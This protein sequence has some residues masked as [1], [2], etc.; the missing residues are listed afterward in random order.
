MIRSLTFLFFFFHVSILMATPED[1]VADRVLGQPNFTAGEQGLIATPTILPAPVDV[2]VA[3][4]GRLYV[5][6]QFNSRILSWP[7]AAGFTN[8]QAADLVIG[9]PDLNSGVSNNGGVSAT[10]LYQQQGIAVD[11]AGNLYVADLFNNRVLEYD[12]PASNDAA[13]DRVFGQPNFTSDTENNGGISA[14]SLRQPFDMDLDAAGNLYIGD[15]GNSRIL[16]YDNPLAS[17]RVADAVIGQGNNFTTGDLNKGGVSA[18]SLAG[19]ASLSID[20]AGQVYVADYLNNRVL[21]YDNPRMGSKAAVQVFGQPNFTSAAANNGGISPTSLQIPR[22]VLIDGSG[23]LYV[24][25]SN[26]SRVLRYD[27]AAV[28]DAVAD[29]QIGQVDFFSGGANGNGIVKASSLRSPAGL[30][31]DAAGDLIVA[32]QVNGRVLSF[33]AADPGSLNFSSDLYNANEA[34]GTATIIVLRA[35]DGDGAVSVDYAAA[36]GTA[37]DADFTPATGTL[38]FANGETSKTFTV[39]IASDTV[40]DDGETVLLTLSNPTGGATLGAVTAATL[41]IADGSGTTGGGAGGD[42]GGGCSLI[43]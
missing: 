24:S 6:D 34:D 8:Q 18:S 9:Q 15:W 33:D 14:S 42:S 36:S 39:I 16:I 13:A 28:T 4:S 21:R 29:F 19:P 2:A 10:S 7:S 27:N 3:P 12:D 37:T 38:N 43:R 25:D 11:A 35:G 32:D 31:L 30:T 17:D 1:N 5:S 20:A 26:N 23:N 40:A 41:T 22:G